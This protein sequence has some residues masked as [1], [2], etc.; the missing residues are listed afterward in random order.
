MRKLKNKII[1]SF[2][3]FGYASSFALADTTEPKHS[4]AKP[5]NPGKL[6]SE[7]RMKGFQKEVNDYR[8]CINKFAQEQKTQSET[9]MVAGNNAIA[10]FNTFVKTELDKKKEDEAAK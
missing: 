7:Q 9:H 1:F 6:A 5:E 10:E 4:C 2:M 3:I 8:D